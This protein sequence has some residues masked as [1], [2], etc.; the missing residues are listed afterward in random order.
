[1]YVNIFIIA[2]ILF[3][4]FIILCVCDAFNLFILYVMK[5][6]CFTLIKKKLQCKSI[7]L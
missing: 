3:K 6:L 1:M 4:I 2:T 7:H 5:S